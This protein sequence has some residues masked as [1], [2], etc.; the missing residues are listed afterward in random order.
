MWRNYIKI[1]FRNIWKAKQVTFVNIVGLSV[2]IAT[3]LLLC[4]TVYKEFSFDRFHEKGDR[5][6]GIY[7]DVRTAEK[8]T[9]MNNT[10]HPLAPAIK[11]EIPGVKEVVRLVKN[12]V[13]VRTTGEQQAINTT[14]T[15]PSFFSIF[16]FPLLKGE[17]R[18]GLTDI[19]LSETT[20][21]NLFGTADVVGKQMELKLGDIWKPFT[22]T[23][24]LADAPENSSVIFSSIVRLEN[25]SDYA[26]SKDNWFS[27]SLETFVEL[28]PGTSPETVE[29]A[30]KVLLEKYYGEDI[31]RQKNAG[32][33]PGAYG[34]YQLLGLIPM[35]ELHFSPNS[36]LGGEKKGLV[37]MLL[38]IAGFLLFIA[39]I[40][41]VN[42]T[43]ARSFTRARE[44]GM[45]KVMGAEKWQLSL[46]LWGE[47]FLLFVFALLVG[48][49]TAFLLL[50][51]Y[52]SLFRSGVSFSLLL[53]PKFI[54]G[55][56]LTLLVVTAFAGG[57]PAAL[58]AR[59]STLL[60]LK[61]KMTTGR[62]NYFRNSLIVTQFV[63]S[64][65]LIIATLIAWR[66]MNY[67]R[68][69]PL[70]YNTSE[71]ISVPVGAKENGAALL[72][73]LR[74]DL[75]GQPGILSITGANTNFGRGIDGSMS[76]SIISWQDGG[77]D[78][79][80]HWQ[81]V[82][83]DY[84]QTMSLQLTGGRDFSAALASDSNSLIIN[85]QMA[86]QFG[87]GKG[88]VGFRFRM[89]DQVADAT[90]YTIIG[91]VKDYHYQSLHNTIEPLTLH[92]LGPD[93]RPSYIFVRVAPGELVASMDKLAASWK[94][95]APETP[96]IGSFVNE[97]TERQY[98]A[99][100]T[101]MR[102]FI[103]GGVLTI[104]ISCMGLFAM[105]MLIIGQRT[106][107]IGIRKVLGA[108]AAGVATLISRDFLVLVGIAILIASPLAWVLMRQ[109]LK[110][111]AYR[112]DIHWSI[113][114]MAG[115]MAMLV[116]ALTVSFQSVRAALMNPVKS[117]RTE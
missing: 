87:P 3:A 50:P 84:V 18:L 99:E 31:A 112:T 110:E 19:V 42:L 41:F 65:L 21:K 25:K 78:M 20:A 6:F 46:Q 66:Q 58:M 54:G 48:G 111:F 115:G 104:I 106:R 100:A 88:H 89:D 114:V 33:T 76:T 43:L 5:I 44:V 11:A 77:K 81:G 15:D 69:K 49:L 53:E 74:S 73:R 80:S 107:E 40:N 10:P 13:A 56:I 95:V 36:N 16:T 90:V 17:T 102:V 70:G 32:A 38:F 26:E 59:A 62:K 45:R 37:L 35:K 23:G 108:S 93:Q 7:K 105:A 64:C 61:G 117:L 109:W 96:F 51:A 27:F 12:G 72:E 97:N 1:A 57:Y 94:R 116:A 79:Q 60:V 113:F 63:F 29:R 85:E 71:V 14:Y 86:R 52:N 4:M 47:A 101:L 9:P 91:I 8:V 24:V 55:I 39:S 83:T 34:E 2:A 92:L 98:R 82:S 30:S 103:S 67:L 68:N 28:Q 22:V 75:K